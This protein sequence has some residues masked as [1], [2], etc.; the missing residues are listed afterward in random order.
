M[1]KYKLDLS[2]IAKYGT[3]VKRCIICD[4]AMVHTIIPKHIPNEQRT[5]YALEIAQRESYIDKDITPCKT[6]TWILNT[7]QVSVIM[8]INLRM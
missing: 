2:R 1:Q 7:K 5:K 4:Q 8:I 3:F 6:K